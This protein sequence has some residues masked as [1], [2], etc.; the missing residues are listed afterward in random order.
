M[1]AADGSGGDYRARGGGV[2]G[3]IDRLVVENFKSYKGEQTIGAFVDFNAI[4]GP[5]DAASRT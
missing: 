2:G 5:N 4:I 3:R 1:A